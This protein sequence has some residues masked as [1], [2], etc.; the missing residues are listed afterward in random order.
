MWARA[1]FM[2]GSN[3]GKIQDLVGTAR[4]ASVAWVGKGPILP[5]GSFQLV[6]TYWDPFEGLIWLRG[7]TPICIFFSGGLY[8]VW[9]FNTN[10]F[11][12]LL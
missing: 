1:L 8:N 12:S 2:V 4:L 3:K 7:P 5:R 9:G 10:V 11:S 6:F